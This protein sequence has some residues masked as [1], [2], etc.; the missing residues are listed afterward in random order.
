MKKIIGIV[1]LLLGIGIAIFNL[2]VK[3]KGQTVIGGADGPTAIVVAGKAG[4]CVSVGIIVGLALFALGIF[5][6]VRKK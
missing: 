2:I 1:F 6:L 4:G 3:I 5:M